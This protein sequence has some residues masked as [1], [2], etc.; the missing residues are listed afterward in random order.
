VE[1]EKPMNKLMIATLG[2]LGGCVAGITGTA[3]AQGDVRDA[4]NVPLR[5]QK[6]ASSTTYGAEI[7][8]APLMQIDEIVHDALAWQL[9]RRERAGGPRTITCAVDLATTSRPLRL[10]L[11]DQF[12]MYVLTAGTAPSV[13]FSA[14]R[15]VSSELGGRVERRAATAPP[16]TQAGDPSVLQGSEGSSKEKETG[17]GWVVSPVGGDDAAAQA[18]IRDTV[19]RDGYALGSAAA[20]N[21]SLEVA[22]RSYGHTDEALGY[23]ALAAE[24]SSESDRLAKQWAVLDWPSLVKPWRGRPAWLQQMVQSSKVRYDPV[25]PRVRSRIRQLDAEL[26]RKGR[27]PS[28]PEP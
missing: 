28:A 21:G 14:A 9:V 4:I 12:G 7:Y 5:W 17:L 10:T 18:D 8:A 22:A 26:S 11:H 6:Q 1:V 24:Q 19:F 13:T 20:S 16:K 27:K 23:Q 2:A 15:S 3:L 25:S